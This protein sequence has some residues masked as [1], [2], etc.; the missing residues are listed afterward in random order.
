MGHKSNI[1]HARSTNYRNSKGG[2]TVL[3]GDV[4]SSRH[5][6]FRRLRTNIFP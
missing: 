1:P 6:R 2:Q 4:A 5:H 3:Y